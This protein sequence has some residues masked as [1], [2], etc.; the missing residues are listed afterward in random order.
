MSLKKNSL[1]GF[2]C[3]NYI[4]FFSSYKKI[5]NLFFLTLEEIKL[6]FNVFNDYRIIQIF[7]KVFSLV[8]FHK[9]HIVEIFLLPTDFVYSC[10]SFLD[11]FCQIFINVYSL[12][13][14]K[15]CWR[16]CSLHYVFIF[17]WIHFYSQVFIFVTSF[18]YFLFLYF[19]T[20]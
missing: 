16:C 12:F 10:L 8:N 9:L 14:R 4:M 7:F 5:L 17:K 15:T 6:L 1:E 20:S 3:E 13:Q 11:N 2:F 18:F 19:L